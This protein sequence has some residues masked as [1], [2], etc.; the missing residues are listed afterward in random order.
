MSLLSKSALLGFSVGVL[1][2]II[3][4]SPAGLFLEERF[5]LDILFSLRG[6][7]KPPDSIVIV[8]I[9]KES[10]T[11]LNL[12][13]DF[14][15]WPRSIHA[16]LV[17][18]LHQGGASAIVFDVVFA[19]ARVP[20]DEAFAKS[21]REAGNVVLGC[22]LRAEKMTIVGRQ[23]KAAGD[24]QLTELVQPIASL[25]DVAA[26]S[27]PFP[28]PKVPAR[29]SQYWTFKTGAGDTPTLPVVALQMSAMGVIGEFL[30]LMKEAGTEWSPVNSPD[31]PDGRTRPRVEALARDIRNVFD[32]NPSLAGRMLA[33][34]EKSGLKRGDPDSYHR[35]RSLIRM[36]DAPNSQFL[37]FYGPPRTITTVPFYAVLGQQGDTSGGIPAVSFKGKTV[38]VGHAPR[39]QYEQQEGFLTVFT[40]PDGLDIAGVEIAA[41]AYGNLLEDSHVSPLGAVSHALIIFFWGLAMAMVSRLFRTWAAAGTVV[42]AML[43]YLAAAQYEFMR[44]ALWYPLI[45]P[46][47]I[48]APLGFAGAMLWKYVDANKER[49]N[50]REALQYYLPGDAVKQLVKS[51]ARFRQSQQLVYGICLWTD[52]EQYTTL[53]ERMTP[54]DLAAFMNRY[55]EIIFNPVKHHGGVISNV[56]GD[57]VLAIWAAPSPDRGLRMKACSA[58]LDIAHAIEET[59]R[60]SS[61]PLLPT[62]IGLHS[63][64][65][66]IGNVGA[67]DHFEYR[68]I[69][70]IVNTTT[71]IE[72]LNKV[73]GTRLLASKEVVEELDGILMRQVGTFLPVGKSNPLALYELVAHIEKASEGHRSGC[74][75]FEEALD[76]FRLRRWHE[77]AEK[78]EASLR[79]FGHDLASQYY[80]D[81][82]THHKENP[83]DDTWDGTIRMDRK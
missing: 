27:A 76:A 49:K 58:A 25:C 52:A 2:L 81:L 20:D 57:S 4:L 35:L 31:S 12:N 82:C 8:S 69:G 18:A 9:D 23:G 7:R 44:N 72:G 75:R 61:L 65:I 60:S 43:F 48:Q 71:R 39:Y 70:D 37:N 34:L 33:E 62:R 10:S 32:R 11:T 17:D 64:H 67:M 47:F 40:R 22:F 79:C 55:F 54:A 66:A 50:I 29:I 3:A 63:G 80:I 21:I 73:L 38:F 15:K 6:D 13:G 1:G 78:F 56:L 46:L 45:V 59:N 16:R 41:T 68:P 5:G 53:S 77:A 74:A 24:L 19:D 28:L 51:H 83:P 36:Y 42:G 14:R 26:A 30:W